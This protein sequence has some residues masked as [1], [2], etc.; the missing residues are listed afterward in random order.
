MREGLVGLGLYLLEAGPA[1]EIVFEYTGNCV[2]AC[3]VD[4]FKAVIDYYNHCD[5]TLITV[6]YEKAINYP[7]GCG[8]DGR[9][10]KHSCDP[11]GEIYQIHVW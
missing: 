8:G 10:I 2:S 4:N 3:D 7:G 1:G 11:N 9:Y 5:E 6:P